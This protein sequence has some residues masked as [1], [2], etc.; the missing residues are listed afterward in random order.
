MMQSNFIPLEK[1]DY[2]NLIYLINKP[3]IIS[4]KCYT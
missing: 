3:I 4:R 2:V 1:R